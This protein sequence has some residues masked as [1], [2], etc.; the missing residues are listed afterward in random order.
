VHVTDSRYARFRRWFWRPPRAPGEVIHDRTVGFL[1]LYYDLV[2][3]AVIIQLA[4]RLAH[5]FTVEGLAQFTVVFALVFIAWVNGSLYLELH[6]GDDG[7]TRSIVFVQIGLLA[8]LAVYIGDARGNTGQEFALA[9]GAFVALSAWLWHD[10]RGED[11]TGHPESV[12]PL[13]GYVAV[14]AI[15][16]VVLVLSALLPAQPR[17]LVWALFALV[18]I[19]GIWLAGHSPNGLQRV[20][21]PTEALV[22]RFGLF[23]IIVLGEVFF[24][25]VNG[26]V[27]IP[28]DALTVATGMVALALGFAFGWIYFDLI[29]RRLPRREGPL[30]ARWMLG[31]LPLTLAI[32]VIGAGG[33]SLVE[34]AHDPATPAGT[35][36]ALSGSVAI[37]LLVLIPVKNTLVDAGRLP[38]VYGPVGMAAMG[39]AVA[40]L[41]VGWARPAPWLLAVLL[42]AILAALWLFTVARFMSTEE[43]WRDRE[44]TVE[45][46][47][48]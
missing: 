1:E 44:G 38:A 15:S 32:A 11:R 6:G 47:S 22:E 20:I 30:L 13:A 21:V 39:G 36:W 26:L 46:G 10:A 48:E 16:S 33:V 3:V 12:R 4:H 42:V 9:Y 8:L 25:V 27:A 19:G 23:V 35:A 43:E 29:G 34:H 45:S 7:R 2:Y 18:W 41:V 28:R 37:A 40:A 5:E 14:L 24:G 31:H 17:F